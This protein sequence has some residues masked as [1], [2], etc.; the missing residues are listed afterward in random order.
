MACHQIELI[1]SFQP[2]L[3]PIWVVT[4][5]DAVKDNTK[6]LVQ[7]EELVCRAKLIEPTLEELGD[8]MAV[9][10]QQVDALKSSLKMGPKSPMKLGPRRWRPRKMRPMSRRASLRIQRKL[11]P[12][13]LSPSL[14]PRRDW[15]LA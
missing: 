11:R 9:F 7:A 10:D 5:V 15:V 6:K 1:G 12:R 14:A 2:S 8:W 4:E 13:W 3:V